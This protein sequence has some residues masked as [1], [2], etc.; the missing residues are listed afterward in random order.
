MMLRVGLFL[1]TNLAVMLVLGIVIKLFGLETYTN[2][3]V[4]LMQLLA[5]CGIIGFTGSFIS[6]ALSKW[7]S[8]RSVGGRKIDPNT[9][10]P[11]ERWV[12]T[13]VHELA[14]KAGIGLPE[15]ALYDSPDVN[16]F[17]TGMN[18][19]NALVAVS[20]GLLQTMSREEAAAVMAHEV[21]HIANGDMVTMTLLQGVINTFVMFAARLAGNFVDKALL[22]NRDGQGIG[23]FVSVIVFELIFGIA[24]STIVLWFSRRRE[25]RADA[26][27]AALYN[28]PAMISA[29]RKL[30]SIHETEAPPKQVAVMAISAPASRFGKLF[31]SHP[32]LEERIQA[33]QNS[34]QV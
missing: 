30:Q 1:L 5:F 31:M 7:V 20:T 9:N 34:R 23:Y 29:L 22:G 17:A 6:L 25:F 33:L 26:G 8:L 2:G 12:L 10:H 32:P 28:T 18:K 14:R 3:Q 19:N 27:S 15:V 11:T 13:T 4:N 21:S 16:A 24:A